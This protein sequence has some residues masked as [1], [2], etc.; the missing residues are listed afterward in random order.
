MPLP[1]LISAVGTPLDEHEHLHVEGLEAHLLDQQDAGID[2]I[3]VAGTMGL[4]QLLRDSTYLSL[5][6]HSARI[7][8]G[9]MEVL[10]GVGDTCA[11]RTL[12]RIKRVTQF[13]IDGV[14]VLSPYLV[15][16]SQQELIDYFHLLA[17]RSPVPVFLYDLPGLTGCKLAME[18]VRTVLEHPNV[19]GIK[20]SDRFDWTRE[21]LDT[22][23]AKSRIVVAQPALL[24]ILIRGGVREHL[25]G[26]FALAPHWTK[27]LVKAAEQGDW[28]LA[29]NW[30]KK[31]NAVLRCLFDFKPYV[32]FE[33]ILNARGIPGRFT[34]SPMR[35]LSPSERESLLAQP[36]VAELL[37][38][39]EQRSVADLVSPLK[40]CPQPVER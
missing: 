31:L 30:Q 6:E 28:T 40:S 3:L 15:R 10:I 7:A 37:A 35:R 36:A 21:L 39:Y 16:F 18:T 23:P 22:T 11:A 2:G 9:H 14:V 4:M 34:P 25:D 26:V 24:D 19:A 12:D 20:C 5:V 38:Y 13:P 17:D 29:A 27:A 33:A 8:G 32:A 1:R